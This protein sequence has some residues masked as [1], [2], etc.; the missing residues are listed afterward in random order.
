MEKRNNWKMFAYS[1]LIL[2]FS[3]TLLQTTEIILGPFPPIIALFNSALIIFGIV[4][5][6]INIVK[7][8]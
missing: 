6:Y 8:K 4:A 7:T 2:I 3:I 5:L 1:I